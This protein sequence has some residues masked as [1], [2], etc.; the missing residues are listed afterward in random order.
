MGLSHT[1]LTAPPMHSF[2]IVFL[3]ALVL[4][5]ATRLWL[6]QRHLRHVGSHR[7]AVPAEFAASI[8]L[9]AHQKAADYTAAKTRLGMIDALLSAFVLLGFTL[10]GGLD[11]LY[12]AW[13]T[14]AA[15]DG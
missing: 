2:T 4:A 3:A 10:L 6:A 7:D 1:V 12:E 11:A 9:P 15:P 14:I 13:A 8:A 5:T